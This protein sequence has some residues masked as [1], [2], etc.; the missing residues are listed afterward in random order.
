MTLW[1]NDCLYIHAYAVIHRPVVPFHA[2][3]RIG[4]HCI[5]VCADYF[6]FGLVRL[7]VGRQAMRKVG[8]DKQ[9]VDMPQPA[10]TLQCTLNA[11]ASLSVY[12]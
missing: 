1:P 4:L 6:G 11:Q 8:I 7:C 12:M 3:C 9:P 2:H 10:C 5:T